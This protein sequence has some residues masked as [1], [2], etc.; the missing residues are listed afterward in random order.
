MELS[1]TESAK[2]ITIIIIDKLITCK[3]NYGGDHTTYVINQ[4]INQSIN[5]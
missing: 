3:L 2:L 1:L 4:S 5:Q